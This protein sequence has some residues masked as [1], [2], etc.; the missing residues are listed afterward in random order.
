M[1]SLVR[2]GKALKRGAASRLADLPSKLKVLQQYRK[3]RD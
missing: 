2:R 1:R 3:C